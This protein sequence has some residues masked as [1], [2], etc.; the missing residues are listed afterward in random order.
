M[1]KFFVQLAGNDLERDNL[2]V[3]HKQVFLGGLAKGQAPQ[4]DHELTEGCEE[5]FL[6]RRIERLGRG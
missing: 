5:G 6:G 1:G 4:S 2:R 3:A